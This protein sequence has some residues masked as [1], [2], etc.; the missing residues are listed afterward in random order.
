MV[1]DFS[2]NNTPITSIEF[3]NKFDYYNNSNNSDIFEFDAFL[4]KSNDYNYCFT[5][6]GD[7]CSTSRFFKYENYDYNSLIGK[8]IKGF[9]EIELS[10]E[11]FNN[12]SKTY[13]LE[14]ESYDYCYSPHLYEMS[15]KDTDE[16]FKFILINFSNGYYD[17]WIEVDESSNNIN[18]IIIIGLPASGKTTY[19]HN[20]LEKNGFKLHD[21]FISNMYSSEF[22]SDLKE[23]NKLCLIDPRLCD[24][25]LFNRII[26]DLTQY[27]DISKLK[28]IL[29]KNDKQKSI[30]YARYRGDL[31][32]VS[33]TIDSYSKIYLSSNYINYNHE[34]I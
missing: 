27:I 1:V 14:E 6:L 28:L 32:K 19:Y 12:I 18:T 8:K 17:G 2:K 30:R 31:E 25:K 7:C 15:F 26:D 33:N 3:I 4:L 9:K 10:D 5:A 20:K 13:D 24:F 29:F 22:I 16:T 34:I 23:N 11:S 21:D